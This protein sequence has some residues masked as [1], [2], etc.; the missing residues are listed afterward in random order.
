MNSGCCL[1]RTSTPGNGGDDFDTTPEDGPTRVQP[2]ELW[3]LGDHRLLCGD[4]TKAEDVAR[5]MDGERAVLI[6]ADPPYGMNLDASYKNSDIN[7]KLHIQ[8]CSRG[9]APVMGDDRD[10][11][12][13]PLLDSF[14]DVKEQFWWGADYYR[15]FLPSG[16]SWLVWD[17]RAGM[18]D[19][20]YTLS[21]FELCWSKAQHHR[22]ILRV[23]WFGAFGTQNQDVKTR[24]HPRLCVHPD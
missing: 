4:S 8:K 18:T 14:S 9:Y 15:Q 24:V 17:K 5:L 11:D 12:P 3:Q 21:E 16:G 6:V 19:F 2:G 22:D 1:S 10:Y 13:R 23:Q 7:S 20:D